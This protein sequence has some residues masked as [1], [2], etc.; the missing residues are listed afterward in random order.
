MSK[1]IRIRIKNKEIFNIRKELIQWILEGYKY[2]EINQT[3]FDNKN[4]YAIS[5]TTEDTDR[6][7]HRAVEDLEMLFYNLNNLSPKWGIK[8]LA[9]SDEYIEWGK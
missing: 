4:Y 1:S 8:A 2:F 7:S 9:K 6:Y 5:P 3:D